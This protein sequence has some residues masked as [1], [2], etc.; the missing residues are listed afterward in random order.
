MKN[1]V[2]TIEQMKALEELGV[3]ISKASMCYAN[4]KDSID[5]LTFKINEYSPSIIKEYPDL[6]FPVF[7]VTDMLDMLPESIKDNYN[8]INYYFDLLVLKSNRRYSC[9]YVNKH[10][11]QTIYSSGDYFLLRDALF[12]ILVKLKKDNKL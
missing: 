4:D 3:D 11:K 9:I 1:Q 8:R 7:T 5:N 6:V 12:D 2:C 10:L